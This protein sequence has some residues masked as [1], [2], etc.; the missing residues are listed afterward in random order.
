MVSTHTVNLYLPHLPHEA[1]Q[2]ELFPALGTA[3]LLSIGKLCDAGCTATFT[4]KTATIHKDGNIIL[5]G[6]R[7]ATEPKLWHINIP[8]AATKDTAALAVNQSTK[9]AD[10]VAFSHVSLFSPPLTTL[11]EALRKDYI[12]G[13]P[14]LTK[15]TLAKYPSQSIAT[16][17]CHLNQTWTKQKQFKQMLAQPTSNVSDPNEAQMMDSSPICHDSSLRA[18]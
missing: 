13:F 15:E 12:I 9:P 4:D 5:Q 11:A 14:G 2:T 17:K 8:Q 6:S 1:T 7:T 16:I 10:L 3:N 18:G